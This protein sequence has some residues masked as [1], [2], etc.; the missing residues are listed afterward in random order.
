MKQVMQEALVPFS[1]N[2]QA[3]PP[4]L[5]TPE[6]LS[7]LAAGFLLTSGRVSSLKDIQDIRVDEQGIKV[8][9]H[10]PLAPALMINQ[11][12]ERLLPCKGDLSMNL[13]DIRE[14]AKKLLEDERHFGTHRIMVAGPQGE[15]FMEDVGRHNAADKAIAAALQKGFDLSSC[16]L[17][18]TGR[19]S[20]EILIK[21]ASVGIP[22][23]FSKKYASDLSQQV[24]KGL[25][26][27]IVGKVESQ[28]P[29]ISGAS[30][31]VLLDK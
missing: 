18:A 28:T 21:A 10:S 4:F 2:G 14:L 19:I 23:L 5:C 7:E 26:M 31:R 6:D 3:L 13:S 27:A 22:L 30:Q 25:D 15:V 12:L 1:V 16:A 24:A 17:G 20:L 8:R 11:R 9:T 29:D